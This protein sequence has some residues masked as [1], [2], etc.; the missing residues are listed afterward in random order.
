MKRHSVHAAMFAAFMLSTALSAV[1]VLAEDGMKQEQLQ[2]SDELAKALRLASSFGSSSL[3]ASVYEN[4]RIT[5]FRAEAVR[6]EAMRLAPSMSRQIALAT[7]LGLDQARAAASGFAGSGVDASGSSQVRARPPGADNAVDLADI[8]EFQRN[9]GL[10]AIGAEEALKRGLTGKGV[11]VGVVDSGIDRRADGTTH[12]AFAGRLDPRSTSLFHWYD[13]NLAVLAGDVAA[14]FNRPA[15]ASEDGNGHGT[16]V[17]GI[18]GAAQDGKGMQGVAPG[19]TIL[20]IQALP[21][22][23]GSPFVDDNGNFAIGNTVYNQNALAICGSDVY[24]IN[25][26]QCDLN[27]K[28]YDT[29]AALAYM[30]TQKDVRVI[31]GSFGPDIEAGGLTWET[32]NLTVEANAVRANLRAGQILTI[33]AGN[34]RAKAPVYGENPSGIGLFPFINPNNAGTLNSSGQRIYTGSENADF[35]DMTDAALAA[36]EAAD[37]INRG[38]IITVVATDSQKVIAEYSNFCGVTAEWCIAAPGGTYDDN[39]ERPIYSTYPNG[40]YTA[41]QGTSMAAPHVA[42]AV[43]VLIEA[44]PTYTPA[45]ITNIIFE[46]AE[47]LGAAGTDLIYGRGFLRL[48][49]ALQSGPAGLDPD[50][51]GE[52]IVGMGS[53]EGQKDVWTRPIDS[54]GSLNKGGEGTLVLLG[55]ASF[56]D[57][58]DVTNGILQ[59]D[60]NLSAPVMTVSS[61]GTLSGNGTIAGSVISDGNVSPGNSPGLLTI[62]GDLTLTALSQTNIEVDG[63]AAQVGAGGFDR[64]SLTGSGRTATV[65]GVLAPILRGIT[66]AANNN[67]TPGLGQSFTFLDVD[68]GTVSGSFASL[69]QP[70]AGLAANTRFDVVY[71][72]SSLALATTPVSYADL[73]SLGVTQTEAART[74]GGVVD[75]LRPAAGL[76][77]GAEVADLFYGLYLGSAA[78]IAAGLEQAT[79]EIYVQSGQAA[80]LSVGRF[81]DAIWYHQTE[82]SRLGGPAG[83]RARFWTQGGTW[84]GDHGSSDVSSGNATFGVD[85]PLESAWVGGA[86]RYEGTNLSSGSAGRANIDT[87]QAGIYGQIGLSGLE[88]LGRGGFS[89][90]SLDVSRRISFGGGPSSALSSDDDGFGGFAEAT[91]QKTVRFADANFIP[92]ATFGYRAFSFGGSTESGA[93]LPLSTPDDDFEEGH[94]TVALTMARTFDLEA[95]LSLTPSATLGYRRDLIEIRDS[96]SASLSGTNF[97]ASGSE[98]GRDAFVGGVKLQAVQGDRLSFAAGYDFDIR[99]GAD[100][101]RVSAELTVRW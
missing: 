45:Q 48:D 21:S 66:G 92:S 87:Y 24:L 52:Y 82:L 8:P 44:F 25:E 34:E 95:G 68:D 41:L 18:I 58:V 55:N 84:F 75:S 7:D 40:G 10:G 4:S 35:S 57:G 16:H 1:P 26:D 12:S 14:G 98:L 3:L 61:A 22:L 29:S 88:L 50:S 77:P 49:R 42:G 62:N 93:V 11:V 80:V 47:D 54:Q 74:V 19:A 76:R 20:A 46:T 59:V 23:P 2:L 53:A 96:A 28:G 64:I 65:G 63:P 51:E 99:K 85:I 13:P 94:A 70:A 36:A 32:G 9:W 33:A 60:G 101:H 67:F 78:G 69:L 56:Q 39:V 91:V 81:A 86:F 89:Y 72:D 15:D 83:D 43:A 37:G 17:A 27:P 5:P 73:Q 97:T 71:G 100:Q 79:G 6:M 90:G 31:N 30:A 38:R